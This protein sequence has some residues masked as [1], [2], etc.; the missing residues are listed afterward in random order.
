MIDGRIVREDELMIAN[1]D[2][3]KTMGKLNSCEKGFRLAG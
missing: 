2:E 3:E 1:L